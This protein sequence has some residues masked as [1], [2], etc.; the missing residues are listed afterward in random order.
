M[1]KKNDHSPKKRVNISITEETYNLLRS[2]AKRENTTMSQLITDW[3][4]NEEMVSV[5]FRITREWVK[6]LDTETLERLYLYSYENHTSSAQAIKDWI[7]SKKVKGQVI[8]GQLN[9]E[10]LM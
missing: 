10:D 5:P 9:W 2:Q 3:V 4:W 6:D 8:P 1:D 7:W